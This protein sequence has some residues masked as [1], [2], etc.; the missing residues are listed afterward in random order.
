MEREE[1]LARSARV[2]RAFKELGDDPAVW[3]MAVIHDLV[4]EWFA[5]AGVDIV[6]QGSDQDAPCIH[7]DC[8]FDHLAG[9]LHK[10][11]PA[12]VSMLDKLVAFRDRASELRAPDSDSVH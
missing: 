7:L 11:I 5:L 1:L 9:Y 4:V 8:K 10:V 12:C 3:D 6:Y 2:S